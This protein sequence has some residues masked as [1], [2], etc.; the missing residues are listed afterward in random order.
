MDVR[1][2]AFIAE[3]RRR[4]GQDLVLWRIVLGA[5]ALMAVLLFGEILLAGS[6]AYLSWLERR[7]ESQAVAVASIQD[8]DAATTRLEDF[9]RSGAQPFDMLRTVGQLK[10]GDSHF[11]RSTAKGASLLE[12]EGWAPNVASINSFESALRSAPNVE[13]VEVRRVNTSSGGSTFSFA[14]TFKSGSF[15]RTETAQR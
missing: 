2:S 14:V 7:N 9:A 4:L 3:Q 6:R 8:R 12:L 13:N 11:T 15:T 5:A 10:P 1:D